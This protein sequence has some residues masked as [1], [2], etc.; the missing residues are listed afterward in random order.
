MASST[1]R[2]R[3]ARLW[4]R[5]TGEGPPV[6]LLHGGPGAPD[7]LEAAAELLP[8]RVHRFEQRG[9]GRSEDAE[10]ND[11]DS[12]LADLDALRAHWGLERFV[13]AG[14]SWGADLALLYALEHPG[15]AA[16]LLYLNGMGIAQGWQDEH[17][18]NVKSRLGPDAWERYTALHRLR[19][20]AATEEA[21]DR[22][23]NE[24]F[25]LA[26]AADGPEDVLRAGAP[27]L[28]RYPLRR[29]V[30]ARL[31]AEWVERTRDP[32][33]SKRVASLRIPAL[34]V[35]GSDD[36]RPNWPAQRLA[37]L[38]PNARYE[39]LDRAGHFP[40]LDRPAAWRDAV[41]PFVQGLFC[42][43]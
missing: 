16:G 15:R 35:Q 13:I 31:N 19:D 7:Y 14:H 33:L 2:V 22:L 6:V 36:P 25:A 3:G 27:E 4:T 40:W 32:A 23:A 18:A 43:S 42:G 10:P 1:V 20:E 30:N 39:E 38:L 29:R 26:I 17:K 11:I 34:F 21:R 9:C 5:A 37:A 8:A 28:F 24:A 12:L 41:A